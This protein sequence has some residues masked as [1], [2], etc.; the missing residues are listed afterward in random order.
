[1]EK[2]AFLFSGQGSQYVGMGKQIFERSKIA[3][4]IFDEASDALSFDLKKLCMEGSKEELTLTCNAQPAI[5]TTS[6]AMYKMCEE[7]GIRADIMAGHS[8][9]EISALTCSMGIN[10]ADAVKLVRKRGEFMQQAVPEGKGAMIAVRTRDVEKVQEIC[11]EV[12]QN[13]K[14]AAISNYNSK[15]QYVVSGDKEAVDAV[16]KSLEKE[17]IRVSYLNVSAPFHS[18]LMQ[19]AADMFLEELKKYTYHDLCVPVL[20]NVTGK[21]YEGKEAIIENLTRQIVEPVQWIKCMGYLKMNMVTH[22]VEAGPGNVLKSLMRHNISDIKTYALDKPDQVDKLKEYIEKTTIPF[23][24][25]AMGIAVATRNQNWSEDEYQKGVVE[26][27]TKISQMQEKIEQ[28]NRKATKEE[29][30]EALNM[31]KQVFET[32]KVSKDEQEMRL[33]QLFR[34]TRTE[35]LFSGLVF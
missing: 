23:L 8:L 3:S 34:D 10:F 22:A 31:L 20:S 1:M 4:D 26:P 28:E 2:R 11:K 30:E 27:Y 29:M 33:K 35:D 24:S 17:G 13:E 15:V 32:K 5:L 18:P 19:P 14:K 12:S 6:V 9:G 21:P 16:A 7:E 25:R